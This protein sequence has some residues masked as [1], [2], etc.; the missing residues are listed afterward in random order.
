MPKGKAP[1]EDSLWRVCKSKQPKSSVGAN[2][3]NHANR[4]INKLRGING[5]GTSE[6]LFLRQRSYSTARAEHSKTQSSLP[7]SRYFIAIF[8]RPFAPLRH[9]TTHDLAEVSGLTGKIHLFFT[10]EGGK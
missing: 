8:S 6:S 10:K 1:D 3:A 9:Q 2:S 5:L 4:K 7:E